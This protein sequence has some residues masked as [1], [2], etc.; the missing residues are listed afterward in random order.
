MRIGQFENFLICEINTCVSDATVNRVSTGVVTNNKGISHDN[1][2]WLFHVLNHHFP[3]IIHFSIADV[4]V[5]DKNAG[6]VQNTK[7]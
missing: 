3:D 6:D 7:A 2:L 1:T 4:V 5:V